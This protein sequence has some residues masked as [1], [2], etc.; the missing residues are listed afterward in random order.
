VVHRS[1][2]NVHP[3]KSSEIGYGYDV[4][5]VHRFHHHLRITSPDVIDVV[6]GKMRNIADPSLFPRQ[7]LLTSHV[8][9]TKALPRYTA[10]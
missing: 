9:G 8:D 2:F 3:L 7:L 1:T 4:S 6:K 10:N 5:C